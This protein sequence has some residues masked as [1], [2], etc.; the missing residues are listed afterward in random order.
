MR[1][2]CHSDRQYSK[3]GLCGENHQ[4]VLTGLL[5][6]LYGF[7]RESQMTLVFNFLTYCRGLWCKSQWGIRLGFQEDR[8]RPSTCCFMATFITITDCCPGSLLC[9]AKAKNQKE[10][11][12]LGFLKI[13]AALTEHERTCENALV[14]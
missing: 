12:S 10:M 13:S 8:H 14:L 2:A 7:D 3:D 4:E 6:T 1:Q 9:W 5:Y 11:P